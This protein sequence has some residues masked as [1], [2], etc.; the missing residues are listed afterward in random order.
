MSCQSRN[1]EPGLGIIGRDGA[2]CDSV[3]PCDSGE[4]PEGARFGLGNAVRDGQD[5]RFGTGIGHLDGERA[6][7]GPG[8]YLHFPYCHSR[9]GYCDFFTQVGPPTAQTAFLTLL[10]R[11]IALAA[12]SGAFRGESFRT[13]FLGGGTPSLLTGARMAR[14]LLRVRE[15][16]PL[17]PDAEVTAEC[18]PESLTPARMAAY[19]EAGVNRISLGIQSFDDEEL[20]LLD[21]PH[22]ARTARLRMRQLRRAGFDNVSLDLIYGLPGGSAESWRRT[23]DEAL[24]LAPDHVSAYLLTLEPRVPMA[25]RLDRLGPPLPDGEEARELYEILRERMRQAGLEQYEISNFARPGRE[26]RHN[27]NY[28]TRG[29]YLGLG[30]SAHSHRRGIRWHNPASMPRWGRAIR[31]GDLPR[32][33]IEAVSGSDVAAE[34]VFLGLRRCEGILWDIVASAMGPDRLGAL[35]EKV[36]VLEA[37][38]LLERAGPRLRL[39]PEAY[40]I[41]NSVFVELMEAL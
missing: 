25:R 17:V 20:R 8:I 26:S 30:P 38:G 12:D 2:D 33:D 15:R 13:L 3:L 27:Q 19:R 1:G 16:L 9:C 40:F 23:L 36:R 11:E 35:V 39:R 21:R 41:S 31:Q 7:F 22:S 4:A 14:L 18:N 10:D 5:T 24:A 28:W 37:E 32:E 29:D 6:R 34:W